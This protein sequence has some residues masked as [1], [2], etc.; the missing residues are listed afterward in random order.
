MVVY[1]ATNLGFLPGGAESTASACIPDGSLVVGNALDAF[2][3]RQAVWWDSIAAIH[4][5]DPL[6]ALSDTNFAFGVSTD[7]AIIVGLSRDAAN[8]SQPVRWTGPSYTIASVP[9]G[10]AAGFILGCSADG[11][12][13]VGISGGGDGAGGVVNA[14]PT[15]WHGDTP[16]VLPLPLGYDQGEADDCSPDGSVVVGN[17]YHSGAGTYV[18]VSWAKPGLVWVATT[19]GTQSGGIIPSFPSPNNSAQAASVSGAKIAGI[20]AN[21]GGA[22]FAGT[23]N[24]TALTSF[25]GPV[26]GA[27]SFAWGCDATGTFVCG[28]S[29]SNEAALWINGT[30]QILPTFAGALSVDVAYGVSYNGLAIVGYGTDLLGGSPAVVWKYDSGGGGGGPP[31]PTVTAAALNMANVRATSLAA[32]SPCTVAQYLTPPTITPALGLRWSD[33][34]G[35]TF[36]NAVAQE[37]GS[38]PLGQPQWNRTGYARDRVFELFWSAAIK[39]ALNGAFVVVNPWKS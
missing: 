27:G 2:G 7:G 14:L 1:L 33:T 32:E 11:S 3:N 30:G 37:F 25:A 26:G 22:L 29:A 31:P 10:A 16:T 20:T 19:L 35:A 17:A 34:R 15:V 13:S 5:L 18:P 36:G 38:S 8:N 23:W 6:F 4:T 39:T 24:P 9:A 21:A 12:V 28:V